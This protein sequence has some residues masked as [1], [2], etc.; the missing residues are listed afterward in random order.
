MTN[1]AEKEGG[2]LKNLKHE[3]FC[4]EYCQNF[5]ATNSYMKVYRCSR[6]AADASGPKLLGNIRVQQRIEELRKFIS[7]KY[8]ITRERLAKELGRIA[9]GDVTG[10]FN[11]DGELKP[12]S[13]L[14]EDQRACVAGIEVEELYAGNFNIG[15]SKKIKTESKTKAIELLSR[16]FGMNEPDKLKSEVNN[17]FPGGALVIQVVQGVAKEDE[18]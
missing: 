2:P 11:D 3:A 14:T 17:N 18:L 8:N 9:F 10:M 13:E 5:N 15:K 7:G 6:P 12:L 4:Q 1:N 16:M